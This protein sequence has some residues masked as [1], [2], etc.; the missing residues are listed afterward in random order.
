M[1]ADEVETRPEAQ[2]AAVDLTFSLEHKGE[3]GLSGQT[4]IPLPG[5]WDGATG[6][7]FSSAPWMTGFPSQ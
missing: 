6:S 7:G 3:P 2:R 5:I 1:T 4:E